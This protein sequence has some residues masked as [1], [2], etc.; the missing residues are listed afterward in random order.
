MKASKVGINGRTPGSHAAGEPVYRGFSVIFDMDGVLVDNRRYH[1]RAWKVFAREYLLPFNAE[2]FKRHFFGRTNDAILR[3]LF[4]RELTPREVSV[5][6]AEKESLYREIYRSDI[7]PARGLRKLLKDLK[8]RSIPMAVATAAPKVN[9]D[10]ALDG[11]GLRSF[12]N[13]LVDVASVKRGKPAPDIYLNA[14]SLLESPPEKCIAV[15]DSLPGI[16]SALGAGMKVI[17]I[18]TAHR[19]QEL[20]HAHLVID[21]FN[22]LT[23]ETLRSLVESGGRDSGNNVRE[24]NSPEEDV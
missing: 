9:L 16:E 8:S 5:F 18:T 23:F 12:F 21:H 14:A 4:S 2:H 24:K 15:E 11:T 22:A 3:G 6:E 13:K 19:R 10:F 7:R 20:S 17:A 1:F